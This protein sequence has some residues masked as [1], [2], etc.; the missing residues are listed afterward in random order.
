MGVIE[1]FVVLLGLAA[2]FVLVLALLKPNQFRIERQT[3]IDAAP[4]HIFAA[5][6]D[7]ARWPAWSP[8]AAKD[9]A[10]T[11]TFGAV[12]AGTGASFAWEGNNKVGKG[13]MTILQ[14]LPPSRIAIRLDFEKP[15]KA[16]NFADFTLE[17]ENGG[18]RLTWSMQGP[19][20]FVSKI[21]DVLFNMD[22]MIGRDFE[23]GLKSLKIQSE[24]EAA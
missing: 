9:P 4:A 15:F 2:A 3:F 14:S 5:I 23:A 20:G 1:T 13:A 11:S 8:W 7:F 16:T 10:A 22:K 19:A 6:N 24:A 18:T 21:M 17:P 12:T